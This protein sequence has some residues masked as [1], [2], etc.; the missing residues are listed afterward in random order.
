M[1]KIRSV[2]PNSLAQKESSVIKTFLFG[3]LDFS[4]SLDKEIINATLGF[5]LSI[6]RFN[7][8]FQID[9]SHSAS[10]SS[11]SCLLLLFLFIIIIILYFK[12]RCSCQSWLDAVLCFVS[13]S[14]F[15]FCKLLL[16]EPWV[17]LNISQNAFTEFYQN[18]SC[19]V[20]IELDPRFLG[21][22]ANVFEIT[23]SL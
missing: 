13:F 22:F 12:S 6:E 10:I 23:S 3:K 20:I 8:L 14:L 17:Q 21:C 7:Y 19:C 4:D 18:A 1:T 15:Y 5:I 16:S 9:L 11:L 2:D